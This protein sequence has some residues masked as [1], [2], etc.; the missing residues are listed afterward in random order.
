MSI[1]GMSIE[2]KDEYRR[3]E[4]IGMSIEKRDEYIGKG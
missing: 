3:D 4:Y 1:E 2:K